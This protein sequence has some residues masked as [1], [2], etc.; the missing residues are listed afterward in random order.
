MYSSFALPSPSVKSACRVIYNLIKLLCEHT[1]TRRAWIATS[2]GVPCNKS[3]S[4]DSA[5]SKYPCARAW[6]S[7]QG[8][9]LKVAILHPLAK[10]T[11]R[12]AYQPGS[13]SESGSSKCFL[14]RVSKDDLSIVLKVASR[15]SLK[16]TVTHNLNFTYT[17][18][19][20]NATYLLCIA[21]QYL[22]AGRG[23]FR[24]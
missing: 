3:V 24:D 9:D 1:M 5:L 17:K 15:L 13:S 21:M 14:S 22:L 18:S 7:T 12:S 23:F 6:A 2:P 8:Q 16:Y 11:L 10:T 4:T 19:S 20:S